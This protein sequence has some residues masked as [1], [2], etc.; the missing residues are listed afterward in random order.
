MKQYINK[1][2]IYQEDRSIR[3]FLEMAVAQ[4]AV[5]NNTYIP[6]G[7]GKLFETETEHNVEHLDNGI[8][9]RSGVAKGVR[10]VQN[11]GDP[12][13][14]L[15]L[16]C[17]SNFFLTLYYFLAKVCMFFASQ[18]LIKTVF[19]MNRGTEPTTIFEWERIHG[20][21]LGKLFLKS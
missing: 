6:I 5:N 16:D 8:L 17:K 3:T 15:V 19:Q 2:S 7:D 11:Y 9:L 18:E 14:A 21:L 13:P 20:L 12:T 1:D 10:I 4:V